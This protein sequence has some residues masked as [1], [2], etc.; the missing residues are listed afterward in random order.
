MLP[1]WG[2]SLLDM[3]RIH[4]GGPRGHRLK[5]TQKYALKIAAIMAASQSS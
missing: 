2:K 4:N 1:L 5:A 3:A